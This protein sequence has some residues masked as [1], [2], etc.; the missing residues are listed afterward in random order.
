MP[1]ILVLMGSDSDLP[2]LSEGLKI[3]E[4]F[5]VSFDV[6]IS[7]AHRSLE[8]T[9]EIVEDFESSKG[10]VVIAAAGMSAH[11]AGVVAAHTVL[12]VIGVP[13]SSPSFAN[14]DSLLSMIEMPPGIPVGTMGNGKSGAKNARFSPSNFSYLRHCASRQTMGI[15]QVSRRSRRRE[16]RQAPERRLEKRGNK[17]LEYVH[18]LL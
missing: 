13:L 11:L 18:N 10:K 6:H 14:L 8:R 3:L 7:S 12:P 9:L 5:S 17:I 4:E 1:D 15:S 2:T 16:G